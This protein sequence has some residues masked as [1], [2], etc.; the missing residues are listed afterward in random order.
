MGLFGFG[1]KDRVIDWSEKYNKEQERLSQEKAAREREAS[2]P[3][4]FF[5]SLVENAKK[6][7][8]QMEQ[9]KKTE[10]NM[11][12]NE[13]VEEKKQKL[14]KRLAEIE[15]RLENISN[16]I[17]HLTQRVELLEKKAGIRIEA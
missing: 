8:E 16:Q 6:Q 14:A 10:E 15:T 13:N 9:E 7:N 3:K 5:A 17:Y 4:T 11:N 1:K 12:S 2:K